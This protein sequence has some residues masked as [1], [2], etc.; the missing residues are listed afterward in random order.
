MYEDLIKGIDPIIDSRLFYQGDTSLI[1][2]KEDFLYKV[3]LKKEPNKRYILDYLIAHYDELKNI[4]TPPI[5]KLRLEENYGIKM[6]YV[7]SVDFLTY[8]RGQPDISDFIDKISILSNNLKIMHNLEIHF[9]DLHHHNILISD[10]GY[11]L[12][13]DL[14]D[15]SIGRFCS[16]HICAVSR[17]LHKVEDKGL[18]YEY[19]LMKYGSLDNECL[20]LMFANYIFSRETQNMNSSEYFE[21]LDSYSCDLDEELVKILIKLRENEDAKDIIRYPYYIGDYISHVSTKTFQKVKRRSKYEN[22]H[23]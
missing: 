12:F 11:P 4:S 22:H 20:A 14:D 15:A 19:E 23:F 2:K 8:L 10:K 17:I 9:T 6:K 5:S 7:N 16:T 21:L 1:Y 18:D 3:Y 13:I